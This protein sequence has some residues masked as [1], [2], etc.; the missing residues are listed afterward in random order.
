MTQSK[1]RK[2]EAEEESLNAQKNSENNPEEKSFL[3]T[4]DEYKLR[5]EIEE[6]QKQKQYECS[7]TCGGWILNQFLGLIR[8]PANIEK[9]DFTVTIHDADAIKQNFGQVSKTV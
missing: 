6:Q 3:E 8:V 7:S 4:V 1:E 2:F 9:I 5:R